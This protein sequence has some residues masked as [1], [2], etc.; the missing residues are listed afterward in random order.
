MGSTLP[1]AP[2]PGGFVCW[3]AA[4]WTGC[5]LIQDIRINILRRHGKQ[6]LLLRSAAFLM[7]S[8]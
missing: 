2:P 8:P 7:T 3:V 5:V 6:L 1:D 4:S